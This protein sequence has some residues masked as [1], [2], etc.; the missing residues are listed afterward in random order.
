MSRTILGIIALGLAL[1]PISSASSQDV[2]EQESYDIAKDAY[3]YA[4]P[5]LL[6]DV[7]TRQGANYAAPTGI[8]T[9]GPYNQFSHARAFPPADFKAVVRANVDTLYS[10][11]HLD[12]G[13]EPIVLSVPAIDRYFMLPLLSFWTDVFAVPGTR[14][15]G[16]NSAREFLL[17]GPSWQGQPPAG[18]EIIR[19]PT[20]FVGVGGRTQTNGV[21][22]YDNVYKIQASYKLTPLSAWGKGNYTAP[23]GIVD[24]AIDMRT[25]QPLQIEKM[26]AAAY[27]AR[28]AE[29]LKDNPPGP[30]DYP[31]IHRLERV[32]F[33][34]GQNFDLNVTPPQIKQAFERGSGDGKALLA[35][36][37]RQAGGEGGKDWVYT[38]RGGVYG[39]DYVY[40]AA[41]ALC[42]LGENLP[43]DAVYPSLST[44]SDGRPLDGNSSYVLHFDKGKFPPVDAF[45]SVTAYDTDGYFIPNALNRMALGDRDKLVTSVDGSLDL[46]IRA[47]TPG[48]DKEANWLPVAKKPFTLLM[49]LYSPK[50]EFLAGSWTPPPV[51]RMN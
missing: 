47:D 21:A 9:Q 6:M 24:P 17:V 43:Q 13:P 20:R 29:L 49:R 28:F 2:S 8:V 45:W 35:K 7:F 44:D 16:R 5:L 4:Y 39:V 38:T 27:F 10:S 18:L 12:L 25:P 41:I 15:T 36:A 26:D 51:Q 42:C 40:R 37:A 3:V 34:V 48:G 32:G 31:M 33:K 19:S 14:T 23:K 30:F 1:A 11:A 46:Y 22:D 50:S